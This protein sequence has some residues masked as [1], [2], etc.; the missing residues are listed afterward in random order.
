MLPVSGALRFASI[1][2]GRNSLGI[3]GRSGSCVALMKTVRNVRNMKVAIN[4]L[5]RPTELL[6]NWKRVFEPCILSFYSF[7]K[8]RK[9]HQDQFQRLCATWSGINSYINSTFMYQ[10]W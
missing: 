6:K 8:K 7:L 3:A 2:L 9:M 5:I 4:A 1:L 10:S